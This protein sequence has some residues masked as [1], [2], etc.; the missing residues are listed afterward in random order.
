MLSIFYENIFCLSDNGT[1]CHPSFLDATQD[2]SSPQKMLMCHRVSLSLSVHRKLLKPWTT[3]FQGC[4][5]RTFMSWDTIPQNEWDNQITGKKLHSKW[6]EIFN[7]WILNSEIGLEANLSKKKIIF[8]QSW[9]WTELWHSGKFS[10][11][12]ILIHTIYFVHIL[13]PPQTTSIL[14]PLFY[15]HNFMVSPTTG[16][17]HLKK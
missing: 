17:T 1:A 9:A 14:F 5:V 3:L 6:T 4:K 15:I 2:T 16:N 7:R 11:F 12:V 8:T 10:T 13:F